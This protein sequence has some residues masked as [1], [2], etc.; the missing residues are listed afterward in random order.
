MW[1]VVFGGHVVCA[2]WQCISCVAF[3]VEFGVVF[4]VSCGVWI[5]V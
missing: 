1:C 3:G 4:G 5:L 2:I